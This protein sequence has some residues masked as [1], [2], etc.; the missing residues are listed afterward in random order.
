[1]R[2]ADTEL[3]LEVKEGNDQ[4]FSKLYQKYYPKT[5]NLI[6]RFIPDQEHAED[7]AQDIFVRVYFGA[8]TFS[9]QSKFSTWLY[10]VTANRC[11]SH[12]KK[13]KQERERCVSESEFALDEKDDNPFTIEN[14]P[15]SL[16]PPDEDIIKHELYQEI[17]SALNKLPPDQKMAFLLLEYTGLSYQEIARVSDTSVQAVE[18]R[19]YHARHKLKVLLKGYV[20]A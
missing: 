19:I 10:K 15:S 14:H 12:H 17:Q 1:M 7:I 13:A 5:L 4:S 16:A 11:F 6:Y 18:R 2:D 8:K 20:S 9:P 3:F